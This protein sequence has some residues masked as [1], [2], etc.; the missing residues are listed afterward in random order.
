MEAADKPIEGMA[1][2]EW[3]ATS[4]LV[5]WSAN[6]RENQEAVGPV[7]ESIRRF[8]WG[9]PIL[10]RRADH[11]VIAGHTRLQAAEQ[12]GLDKVPVRWLDLDP[13]QARLLALADNRL[14]EVASWDDGLLASVLQ[15]LAEGDVDLEGLGWSDDELADYLD[16]TMGLEAFDGLPEGEHPGIGQMM[17]IVSDDQREEVERALAQVKLLGPFVDTGNENG[18]GNALARLAEA[19]LTT[20]GGGAG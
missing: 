1:A 18:N 10:A 12:L 2:A 19:W 7:V 14:G 9:A 4:V 15:E 8:G 20:Q 17:F 11:V 13:D 5:P 6:P 16:P 3:V